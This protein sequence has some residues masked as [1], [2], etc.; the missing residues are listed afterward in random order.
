MLTKIVSE[1]IG[2]LFL[3]MVVLGSGVMG[4]NLFPSQLGLALLVNSLATGAGLYSLIKSFSAISHAHF[5][6]VVSILEYFS[7]R[8]SPLDLFFFILAQMSG[9]FVGVI[10]VHLMFNLSPF[11]ISEVNRSGN[12]LLLSEFIATFG[13]IGVIKLSEKAKNSSTA[14]S[15]AC[16]IGAGYWFTSS[17]ALTNPAVCFARLFTNTFGGMAPVHYFPIL[18]S[19]FLGAYIAWVLLKKIENES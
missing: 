12:H 13:L 10:L 1:F 3:V 5:N 15:V 16:Y 4:E 18:I 11:V 6:P 14:F 2:T 9:A 17:T 8:L 7:K 19:Q